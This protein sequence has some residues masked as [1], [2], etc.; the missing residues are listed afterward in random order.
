MI[1]AQDTDVFADARSKADLY[2]NDPER[3]RRL[4]DEAEARADELGQHGPLRRI[5]EDLQAVFRLVKQVRLGNYRYFPTKSLLLLIAGLLYF[6]WPIDL[7]PDIFPLLGWLDD[8]TL[9]AWILG[10]IHVDLQRFRTWE[11]N[12]VAANSVTPSTD[13]RAAG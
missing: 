5:W 2:L 8:A 1:A 7:V 4:L 6:I 10:S 13:D 9:L 11:D 12:F 3:M